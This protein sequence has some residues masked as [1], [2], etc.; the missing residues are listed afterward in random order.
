MPDTPSDSLPTAD[1]SQWFL[2]ARRFSAPFGAASGMRTRCTTDPIMGHT[3]PIQCSRCSAIQ[4]IEV[5]DAVVDEATG[6]VTF[7]F[8]CDCGFCKRYENA[9]IDAIAAMVSDIPESQRIADYLGISRESYESC[10]W[11]PDVRAMIDKQR[12]GLANS[13]TKRTLRSSALELP[14]K[15][16]DRWWLVYN[17]SPLVVFDPKSNEYG[18]VGDNGAVRIVGD[19]AAVVS[20]LEA[21]T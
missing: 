11:P 19:I 14:R 21:Q 10:V 1:V 13:E 20:C 6:N 12:R 4:D 17:V 18:L 2:V 7:T 8:S 9:S 16:D 5:K 15:H 3:V